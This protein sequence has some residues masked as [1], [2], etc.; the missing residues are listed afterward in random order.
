[1]I[2][3]MPIVLPP[4]PTKVVPAFENHMCLHVKVTQGGSENF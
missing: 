1:M 3:P 2:H 4:S